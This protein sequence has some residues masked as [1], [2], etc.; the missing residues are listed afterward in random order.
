MGCWV[1]V[2]LG[3]MPVDRPCA[4]LWEDPAH[5]TLFMLSRVL[6]TTTPVLA[7]MSER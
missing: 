4:S 6:V 5:P 1:H 3:H 2:M 7:G